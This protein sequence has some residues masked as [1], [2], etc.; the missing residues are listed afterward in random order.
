[1][2]IPP[3]NPLAYA[4]QVVIPFTNQT[5][6]SAPP[7]GNPTTS[8]NGFTV[9]TI[10][11]NTDTGD[12]FILTRKPLGVADWRPI[13]GGSITYP[14]TVANGGTNNTSFTPYAPITAGTT[15]T[16]TFQSADTGFSNVGYVLTST[17]ASSLPTWQA[18]SSGSGITTID[19]DSGSISG[20]SVS[21][22]ANSGSANCG[23][24]VSFTA[25]SAT[26]LDL[27]VTD[28]SS[29]T[30][31]GF[32]AGNPSITGNAFACTGFGTG[33]LGTLIGGTSNVA[34]GGASLYALQN[35]RNN[36][37]TGNDA[38]LQYTSN[39]SS[40]IVISNLGTTGDFNTIR[41]GTQGSGNGQQD[42]CYIAGITG[43]TTANSNY[44]TVDTTTGQLGSTLV[45]P[46]AGISAVVRQVFTSSGTYT[47][48]AGM[49]YCNIE[50]LGAGGA[51]GGANG[52][53]ANMGG[54]GGGGGYAEGIFSAATIGASQTV[55]VGLGATGTSG[56]GTQGGTS[57]VGVLISATGGFG[58]ISGLTSSSGGVGGI[59]TG[60]DYSCSGMDGIPGICVPNGATV[61]GGNGGGSFFGGNGA[62]SFAYPGYYPPANGG[63]ASSYGGGG[64]G[65]AT[66]PL[67]IVT[68]GNGYD[69][70]VI[71]TEY[72]S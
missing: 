42:T 44:V 58:G 10:W 28:S 54:G 27:I 61:Q 15:A 29:N 19:G 24:S 17:G 23:S 57:S 49:V 59:G 53:I 40:N 69:G 50:S 9:P 12:A 43:V 45:V 63:N 55:T 38:G 64:G 26:E 65:A 33:A 30:I 32:E 68:G 2:S 67:S 72:V 21:L 41:I 4:G 8:D 47:P 16:G 70:I 66:F 5:L 56:S 3:P 7:T 60:G 22:L 34:I 51:G 1:M 62:G 39:E 48:T 25:A 6:N 18:N 11:D 37:A 14:I 13:G 46:G 36:I 35:G 20:S 31:I 71:V 52:S